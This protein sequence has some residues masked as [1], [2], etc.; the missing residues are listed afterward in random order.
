MLTA[1]CLALLMTI[2]T[3]A[4]E[5]Y[6]RAEEDPNHQLIITTLAG[7]RIVIN[8]D[9]DQNQKEDQVSF[10]KIAIS[11]DGAAV[12]WLS[13]YPNC[14]T[15]YPI[16][17]RVEVYSGGRRRTFIPAIVAW[18]WCFVDGADKIAAVST[19]VHG[20]QN[21]ILELWDV[22]TGKRLADFT[23]MEA[24]TYPDA[25]SWVV[26]IRADYDKSDQSTHSCSTK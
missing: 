6:A 4:Q 5:R 21:E 24:A 20:A 8:K 25:P 3:P 14:C 12:G 19:T 18:H 11:S 16:P 7:R 2:S 1:L 13:Y 17:T 26:A 22:R 9:R 23:W 10:G 15:S